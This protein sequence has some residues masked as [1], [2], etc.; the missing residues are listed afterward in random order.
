MSVT[1]YMIY[2]GDGLMSLDCHTT[3]VLLITGIVMSHFRYDS[4]FFSGL[5]GP[6]H[7]L[8]FDKTKGCKNSLS[9]VCYV[10][11][12]SFETIS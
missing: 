12:L 7:I 4:F 2:S 5:T 6:H 10:T 9:S 11:V 1:V 3:A 8:C